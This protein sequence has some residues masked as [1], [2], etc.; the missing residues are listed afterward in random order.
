MPSQDLSPHLVA[1]PDARS[2]KYIPPSALHVLRVVSCP[3]M[4]LQGNP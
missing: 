3:P 1:P 2:E 4:F